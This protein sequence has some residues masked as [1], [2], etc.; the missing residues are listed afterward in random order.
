[1]LVSLSLL[2]MIYKYKMEYVFLFVFN[3]TV[4]TSLL[5]LFNVTNSSLFRLLNS[6]ISQTLRFMG[7]I[8]TWVKK[9]R[10]IK[11]TTK[12]LKE[13]HWNMVLSY[14]AKYTFLRIVCRLNSRLK[15]ST[16]NFRGCSEIPSRGVSWLLIPRVSSSITVLFIRKRE[17]LWTGYEIPCKVYE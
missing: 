8:E 15:K 4:L 3:Y 7:F 9:Y 17:C 1:M 2:R 11:S 13:C 14:I 10:R 5:G 16:E 6:I 12:S